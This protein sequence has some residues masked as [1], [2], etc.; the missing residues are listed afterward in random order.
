MNGSG[1]LAHWCSGTHCRDKLGA[2]AFCCE[3]FHSF[4]LCC[5]C[6][7]SNVLYIFIFIIRVAELV[8]VGVEAAS[9]LKLLILSSSHDVASFKR[10]VQRGASCFLHM[11]LVVAT[12]SLY[13]ILL[14]HCFSNVPLGQ[15]WNSLESLLSPVALPTTH[16]CSSVLFQ[17]NRCSHPFYHRRYVT[18]LLTA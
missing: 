7:F 15:F 11:V 14:Y 10:H 4:Y 2:N 16:S 6:D 18:L 3:N 5:V 17:R 13:S 8:V 12:L 9:D 1:D